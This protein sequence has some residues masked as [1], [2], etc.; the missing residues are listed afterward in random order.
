M[1][2]DEDSYKRILFDIYNGTQAGQDIH[3]CLTDVQDDMY[4]DLD[5][6]NYSDSDVYSW[7]AEGRLSR[8]TYK[9]VLYEIKNGTETDGLPLRLCLTVE[10]LAVFDSLDITSETAELDPDLERWFKDY[11]TE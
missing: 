8:P 3:A 5:Q 9:R 11:E 6:N 2:Q 4:D 1:R 7:S 10:Q